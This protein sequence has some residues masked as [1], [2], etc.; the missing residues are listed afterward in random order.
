[1]KFYNPFKKT[2]KIKNKGKNNILTLPDSITCP[3]PH[4]NINGSFCTLEIDE[5]FKC[6]GRLDILINGQNNRLKIGK[7][8]NCTGDINIILSG[9]ISSC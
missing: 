6:S 7:N 4:I 3:H 8:F 5:N 2:I 9:T 1:M